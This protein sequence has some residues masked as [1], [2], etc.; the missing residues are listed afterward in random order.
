MPRAS[1]EIF[2]RF[3]VLFG[4]KTGVL[5]VKEIYAPAKTANHYFGGHVGRRNPGRVGV[6]AADYGES[7]S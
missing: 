7:L 4:P 5:L 6:R 1:C 3:R 2:S